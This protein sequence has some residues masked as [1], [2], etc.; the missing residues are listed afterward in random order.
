MHE[1]P[2]TPLYVLARFLKAALK[3]RHQLAWTAI[4]APPADLR[5]GFCAGRPLEADPPVELSFGTIEALPGF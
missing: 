5:H 4:V 2:E 3:A 1:K